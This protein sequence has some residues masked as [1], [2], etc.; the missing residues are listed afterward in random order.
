MKKERW[1]KII[2]LIILGLILEVIYV[3]FIIFLIK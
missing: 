2:I 1:R 3:A